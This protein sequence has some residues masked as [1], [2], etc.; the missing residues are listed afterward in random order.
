MILRAVLLLPA[1]LA[2]ACSYIDPY[3]RPGVWV[4]TGVSDADLRAEVA[5]PMDLVRGTGEPGSVGETAALAVSKYRADHVRPLPAGDTGQPGQPP[6][7]SGNNN[8]GY[9]GG[10]GGGGGLGGLAAG[11]A[12][13]G[14]G[15]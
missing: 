6:A 3:E 5:D 15:S 14:G 11:V 8:G 9:G 13:G 10:G 1:L 2:T 7:D 4:P 12:G